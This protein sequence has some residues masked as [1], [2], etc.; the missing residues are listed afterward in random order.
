MN[1]DNCQNLI[2]EFIGSESSLPMEVEAH[3]ADCELCNVMHQ[4]FSALTQ[5]C[6][7]YQ[8]EEVAPPNA[9]ALWCRISNIIESEMEPETIAPVVEEKKSGFW[10]GFWQ[11]NWQM[12]FSQVVTAVIGVALVSSL[13]TIVG[14]RN[15]VRQP[16]ELANSEPTLFET[17]LS[18]AGLA[19]APQE[20]LQKKLQEK[21]A[22][23]DYWNTRV[24]ARRA[25]WKSNVRETFDRNL[26]EID[27]IVVEYSQTLK[28][29]P[30]DELS[31]E[32][33]NA[34]LL[35]KMELLREF[36]EL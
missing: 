19:P 31:E 34:A 20:E 29:N 30:Q 24:Q 6:A 22:V 12:S 25:Q 36:S 28:E 33:L 9:Q 5:F 17:M 15:M 13:L 26:R 21:Q 27:Q 14:V 10:A 3:L 18:S 35:E 1:C 32:M 23:I 4:D 7:T 2:S 11:K 16:G 8:E